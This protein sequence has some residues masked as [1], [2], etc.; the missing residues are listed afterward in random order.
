VLALGV[1]AYLPFVIISPVYTLA[2]LRS[3]VSKSS[4]QTVWGLIDGNLTT[5]NFGGLID[6]IDPAK[7][8]ELMGNPPVIPGWVTLAACGSL[9]AYLFT[10]PARQTDRSLVAFFGVTW[11]IFLLWSKG[12]S[13]PWMFML[14]PLI[15]LAFPTSDGVLAILVFSLVNYLEWPL[16]FSRGFFWGLYITAPLRTLFIVGLLAAFFWQCCRAVHTGVPSERA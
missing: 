14:I 11:C 8:G 3:Q 1:A 4:W 9:Y 2:S 16:L 12:W 15:L 7:A 6:R 5:G 13:T 10:R